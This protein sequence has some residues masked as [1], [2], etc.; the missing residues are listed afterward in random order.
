[1]RTT[2]FSRLA[3]RAIPALFT[4]ALFSTASADAQM[5]ANAPSETEASAQ[6]NPRGGSLRSKSASKKYARKS[7]AV[8]S[9]AGLNIPQWGLA[10]DA[11]FDPRLTDLIPGYHVVNIVLT[12]RRDGPILLNPVLDKWTIVDNA[13][14]NHTARNHGKQLKGG[15]WD[16]LPA[17]LRKKLG[18][19]TSVKPGHFVTIDVFVP[20]HVDLVNFREVSWKSHSLGKEFSIF[21]DYEDSLSIGDLNEQHELPRPSTIQTYS[22]G[23][24]LKTREEIL[25]PTRP[26]KWDEQEKAA[27]ERSSNTTFDPSFDDA[28]I[29]R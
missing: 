14:K 29:I 12:N 22:E 26:G 18:Y 27:E 24:Y 25:N 21:T 17:A 20:A 23:D 5:L 16:D 4:I 28:I 13:G 10:I 15:A 7:A 9:E 3:I 8:T 2:S 19:P 11:F 6:P 1:M